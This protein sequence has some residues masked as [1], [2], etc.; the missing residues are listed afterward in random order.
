MRIEPN[1]SVRPLGSQRLGTRVEIKNLN[2]FR[3][4]ERSIRYEIERQSALI[5]Q[6]GAVRQET[7]GWDVALEATFTQRIKEGEEDY[8]YFPE[9]DLPPLVLESAWIEAIRC[10]LPELPAAR[11]L[12]FQEKYG[13]NAYDASLLVTEQSAADFYE[14]TLSAASGIPPKLAAN[15]ILGELFALLNQS[16]QEVSQCSLTPLAMAG[17]L[18]SIVSEEINQTTA[19]T[20]MAEMFASRQSAETIISARGLAPRRITAC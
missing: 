6:G 7:L 12:R 3:A 20:V 1:V 2:S 15:W 19:K 18:K 14:Q 13:L 4:L 16:G 10:S 11:Q 17:L 8:R 9:P 5:S